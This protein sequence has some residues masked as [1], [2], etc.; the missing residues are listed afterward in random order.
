[1]PRRRFP[2]PLRPDRPLRRLPRRQHLRPLL[3]YLSRRRQPLSTP[4][5]PLRQGPKAVWKMAK[6]KSPD[7]SHPLTVAL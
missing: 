3:H 2:L 5:K 6:G 1:M 4:P 7:R